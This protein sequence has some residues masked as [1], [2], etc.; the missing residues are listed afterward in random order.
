MNE[1]L[2][3][4]WQGTSNGFDQSEPTGE[5]FD[6]VNHMANEQVAKGL[7]KRGL[8]SNV[9]LRRDFSPYMK[10]LFDPVDISDEMIA[11]TE[12]LIKR[13]GNIFDANARVK[14]LPKQNGKP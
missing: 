14:K 11:K 13:K 1:R 10:W 3:G 12:G 6:E 5:P 8:S 2:S 4:P 9:K 7:V